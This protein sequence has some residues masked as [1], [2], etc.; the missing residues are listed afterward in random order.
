MK[1]KEP[2]ADLGQ[3]ISK[4]SREHPPSGFTEKV[5]KQLP[6]MQGSI[7]HK[8]KRIFLKP[9]SARILTSGKQTFGMSDEPDG[10]IYFFVTGF[11]YLLMGM[12]LVAGLRT[13]HADLFV[14]NWIKAQVPLTMGIAVWLLAIGFVLV[15][16][17]RTSIKT[18]KYGTLIYILIAMIN[19]ILLRSG[20]NFPYA[21]MLIIGFIV[22]SL[23]MGCM[24]VMVV[25]HMEWRVQ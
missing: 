12:M 23:C 4:M 14:T 19:G 17:S 9:L 7:W 21:D 25:K 22:A 13:V 20:F 15:R 5:M 6:E 1:E 16:N 3:R 18:A 2:F 24:L 11:F 8:T 10:A